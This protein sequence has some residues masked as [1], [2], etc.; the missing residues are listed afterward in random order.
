LSPKLLAVPLVTSTPVP[1]PIAVELARKMVLLRP[2]EKPVPFPLAIV[3]TAVNV[4]RRPMT[5][6]ELLRE[7]GQTH[8]GKG[9]G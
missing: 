9:N 2:V 3:S 6:E 4:V 1:F 5:P 7:Y 8:S